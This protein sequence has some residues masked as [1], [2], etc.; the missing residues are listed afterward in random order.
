MA[1]T[2]DKPLSHAAEPTQAIWKPAL[3]EAAWAFLVAAVVLIIVY[4]LAFK[5]IHPEFVRFIGQGAKPFSAT[6]KDFIPVSVGKGRQVGGQYII[7][8]FNGDE[9][10][11]ALPRAFRAE[12][13]PF[14]KVDLSGLTRYSKAKIL[15]RQAGDPTTH[16]LEFNRNGDQTTQIAMVY[17]NENYR[18]KIADVALLF[19]DGPALG[20]GNNDDAS[21]LINSIEFRPF[22]PWGVM[23]Q[24][25]E[26]WTS[27]PLLRG[28][29]NNS[30][31]GIHPNGML[32]PNAVANL[33]VATGIVVSLTF[34]QIQKCWS[35]VVCIRPSFAVA[36]S[37]CLY[38]WVFTDVLRWHWRIEQLVDTY[39]RYAGLLLEERVKNNDVRC[40]RFP[41]N[42]K[43]DLLPYF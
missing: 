31:R 42:C 8:E 40:A 18:G 16:A 23:E 24:I 5:H 29:S 26:D 17:G 9:A 22:S 38:G 33:L 34:R 13:Y 19:Y 36:L 4:A 7:E 15:W 25:Y 28:Y 39:E 2:S 6:G 10:I 20:F 32:F 1:D 3:K 37:L 11:L 35:G 21:I 30:V 27:P 12:D 41:E 43:A 14:I